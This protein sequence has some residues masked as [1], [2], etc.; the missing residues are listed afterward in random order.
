LA[1]S[2]AL[3]VAASLEAQGKAQDAA[4]AYL[5]VTSR[6]AG[7]P[8]DLQ[9]QFSLGRLAEAQGKLAD[10]ENYYDQAARV[11]QAGGTISEEA[12]GR[13][14]EIKMKLAATQKSNPVNLL[15]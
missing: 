6:Y 5:K 11:G 3:G 9:A 7:T 12:Q 15:K 14:Y 8:A 13:A 4:T 1:A 10:A 2:A